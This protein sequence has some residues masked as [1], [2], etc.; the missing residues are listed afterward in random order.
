M[1][2]KNGKQLIND[3]KINRIRKMIGT[4]S[5]RQIARHIGVS[6]TVVQKVSKNDY[7]KK[8][9]VPI[10]VN[11]FIFNVDEKKNWLVCE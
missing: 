2:G 10:K 11:R 9:P 4:A 7:E 6:Y 5:L 1:I 8:E 3:T